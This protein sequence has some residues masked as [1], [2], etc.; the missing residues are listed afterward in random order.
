MKSPA[1]RPTRAKI[2]VGEL[3]MRLAEAEETL[4]AIRHGTVDA[5]VIQ[6]PQ[7]EQVYTLRTADRSYR[8]MIES[9]SEGLLTLTPK[10][11]VL[12]ANNR[13]C[14][15]VG[16]PVERVQGSSVGQFIDPIHLPLF[17]ALLARGLEGESAGELEVIGAEGQRVPA[18]LSFNSLRADDIDGTQVLVTDLSEQKRT[19]QIVEAEEL[20]RSILDQAAEAI[21]V[22]DPQGKIVRASAA[23]EMLAGRNPLRESFD[24]LF[25]LETANGHLPGTGRQ[26]GSIVKQAL[27]GKHVR[28][29]ESSLRRPDGE[30]VH[31]LVSA[32]PLRG[33][34]GPVIGCTVALVDITQSKRVAAEREILLANEQ[35]ARQVAEKALSLRDQFISSAAHELRTPLTSALGYAELLDGLRAGDR[36]LPEA[37]HRMLAVVHDQL[38]RLNEMIGELLDITRLQQGALTLTTAPLDVITLVSNVVDQYR[39]RLRKHTI[40]FAGDV[41]PLTLNGDERRL[42][43][44]LENLVENAIKYSPNGGSISVALSR[45]HHYAYIAIA[46]GGIGIPPDALPSVFTRFYRAAN[47]EALHIG[48]LGIGLHVSREIVRAHGGDIEVTSR[49]NEGS[50]FTVRLPL[51]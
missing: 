33:K 7:G 16:V 22:L 32:G 6:G 3:E 20:A 26:E 44:V 5:L 31:L 17:D 51:S 39:P 27:E 28:N 23:A 25:D 10:G 9:M 45:D 37:E 49:E 35:A 41:D 1:R 36:E 34:D 14:R 11:Y 46:D 15:M 38:I 21:L 29:Q 43:Q 50:A 12:Y 19:R 4:S 18:Y 13:F 42:R 2:Q 47:A 24:S 40:N 48:G 8:R 30:R